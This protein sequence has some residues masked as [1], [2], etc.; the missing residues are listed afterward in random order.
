MPQSQPRPFHRGLDR[1]AVLAAA[2]EILHAEGRAALT[3]RRLARELDVEAASLYTHIRG[4]DDLI[5]GMIDLVLDRVALP[6]PSASWRDELIAGFTAYRLTLIAHPAI[7]GLMTERGRFSRAQLRLVERAIELLESSGLST[8]E[9]VS[10][11]VTLVAFTLGFVLQEIA[12]PAT[13]PDD[14]LA[15]SAVLMRTVQALLATSVESRFRAG[16][17]RILDGAHT[18]HEAQ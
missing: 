12:R 10:T 11:Q 3:M 5:D 14:V 9:A 1:G 6:D 4:K 15:S 18:Q 7:V 16:L 8:A 17:D 2:L 13:M